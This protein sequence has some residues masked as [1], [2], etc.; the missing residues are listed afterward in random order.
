MK[1][2]ILFS[3]TA[4][5]ASS[6]LAADTTPKEDITN[7]AKKLGEKPNYS[8]RTTIVV[9]DDAPFKPGPTDGKT[10]K[11]GLTWVSMRFFDN[12]M[13]AVVKG[14]K[15]ALTDQDGAWKSLEETEKEEGPGRFLGMIVRNLKTPAKEAAELAAFA[16][17]LK[18]EG[19]VYSSD[20]TEEGAKALQTFGRRGG[21][22]GPQVSDAKGSVKLW[23]NEGALTKYEFKLKGKISF[24]GNDFPNERTTTVEIKDVGTTK[25]EV[26]EEARKK[27]SG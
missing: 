6:L 27:I 16:K 9:P 4:L 21:S 26:P 1:R 13:Q 22:E 17:N 23:V 2:N 25:L 12:K 3:L 7:A 10:G 20:L 24:N 19:E 15:G 5:A 11:E 8:W 18:Q 14:D